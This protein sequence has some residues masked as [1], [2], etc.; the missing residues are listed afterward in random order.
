[1]Q[2]IIEIYLKYEIE[3]L[4]VHELIKPYIKINL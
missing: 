4:N 3:I 2:L 1:M